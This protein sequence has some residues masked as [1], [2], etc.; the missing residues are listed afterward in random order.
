M[1][2]CLKIILDAEVNDEEDLRGEEVV[3]T[4]E[5]NVGGDVC[6]HVL[7][8]LFKLSDF[9]AQGAK[10]DGEDVDAVVDVVFEFVDGGRDI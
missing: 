5:V 1:L 10:D 4:G 6:L 9:E 2:A 7:L 3:L 8:E